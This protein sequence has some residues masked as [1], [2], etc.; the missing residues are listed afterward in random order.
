MDVASD[1][2]SLKSGTAS[3]EESYEDSFEGSSEDDAY[4]PDVL[5]QVLRTEQGRGISDVLQDIH[6]VLM[7][8]AASLKAKN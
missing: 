1:N 8:I 7:D 2:D 6:A 3:E 5:M 4:L